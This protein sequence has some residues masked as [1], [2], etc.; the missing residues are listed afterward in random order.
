[1]HRLGRR[2][3]IRRIEQPKFCLPGRF[4]R[5]FFA[6]A[7]GK[8]LKLEPRHLCL[9]VSYFRFGRKDLGVEFFGGRIT[10]YIIA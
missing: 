8:Q 2:F 1:M 6:L 10:L 7:A 3:P 9:R 5:Q 4:D